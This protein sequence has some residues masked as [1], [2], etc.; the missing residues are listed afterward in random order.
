MVL[1]ARQFKTARK[2][3]NLKLTVT[4]EKLGVSQPTLSAWENGNK[5]PTLDNL[6]K[7]ADMYGVTTDFLL[8]RSQHQ[9]KKSNEPISIESLQFMHG[10]PVW[11]QKY[12]WMLVDAISKKLIID[13][14]NSIAFESFD[15]LDELYA[16]IP[17][18]SISAIPSGN[19]I[20]K[21]KLSQYEEI[22]LEPISTDANLRDELKGWYHIKDRWA[23]N[24]FGNRFY[25]DTYGAKWLAFE[26]NK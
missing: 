5:S 10:N 23:E 14:E 22:W 20:S 7:M 13:S 17:E 25:L 18:M 12:G 8:G 6:E 11:S 2:M 3:N 26:I 24:E 16:V 15:L 9:V 19:P 4:A 21:S 1:L